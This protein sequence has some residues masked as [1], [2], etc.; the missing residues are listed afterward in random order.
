MPFSGVPYPSLDVP[1]SSDLYMIYLLRITTLDGDVVVPAI[2]VLGQTFGPFTVYHSS[3]GTSCTNFTAFRMPWTGATSLI[4]VGVM[5]AKCAASL[6]ALT[7]PASHEIIESLTDPLPMAGWTDY[8]QM[9]VS[10][11]EGEPGICA[12]TRRHAARPWTASSTPRTGPT[13][14]GRA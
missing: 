9:S 8:S 10:H 13:R 14:A 11:P 7:G 2:T 4:E 6:N 1:V 5:P 3:L 12:S